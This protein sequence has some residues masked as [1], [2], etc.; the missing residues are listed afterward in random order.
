MEKLKGKVALVTGASRGIG[1]GIALRLA[2]DG[3]AVAVHYGKSKTAA[4]EVVRTIR[5]QGGAAFAIGADLTSVADIRAL[6]GRLDGELHQRFGHAGLDILVNNAGIGQQLSIEET[7]EA[8]LDE[9]WALHVK[10]PIFVIREALSRLRDGGRILNLSSAVT[11][12]ALPNLLGYSVTKGAVNTLTYV[13]AQQ[14]GPRQI[15]VNALAPG[16]V[17]TDMNAD[18]LSDPIGRQFAA[19][20]SAFGRWAQPADIADIAAF[21]ASEDGR[22]VTGQVIDASGGSRL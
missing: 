4:E 2:K 17:E 10:G 5:E 21:L 1:R 8:S 9:V 18:L 16:F 3:A 13:L 7:T 20:F 6:F 22:W 14:L 15:T 12:I 11:R 19:G